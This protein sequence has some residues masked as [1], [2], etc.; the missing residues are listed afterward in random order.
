MSREIFVAAGAASVAADAEA[1]AGS[2]LAAAVESAAAVDSGAVVSLDAAC[3]GLEHPPRATTAADTM[4]IAK[5]A[6]ILG[7]SPPVRIAVFSTGSV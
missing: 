7:I 6:L 4:L 1:A 2:A 5:V 3:C